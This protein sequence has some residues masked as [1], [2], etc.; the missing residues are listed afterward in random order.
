MNFLDNMLT[1]IEGLELEEQDER[2]WKA[3]AVATA[4]HDYEALILLLEK[5]LARSKVRGYELWHKFMPD[6]NEAQEYSYE[7]NMYE[8]DPKE[9]WLDPEIYFDPPWMIGENV[10]ELGAYRGWAEDDLGLIYLAF[11]YYPLKPQHTR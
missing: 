11:T 3:I 2:L 10:S 9:N 6:I 7:W 8:Q 1:R 4:N 5:L